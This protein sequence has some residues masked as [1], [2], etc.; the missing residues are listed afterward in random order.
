MMNTLH[1]KN[2]RVGMKDLRLKKK[3]DMDTKEGH[4]KYSISDGV[5]SIIIK[6]WYT[7]CWRTLHGD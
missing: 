4:N 7:G 3:V 1:C 5:Y 2:H 6:Q